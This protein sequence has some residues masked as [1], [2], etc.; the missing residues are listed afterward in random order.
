MLPG[1]IL[2]SGREYPVQFSVDSGAAQTVLGSDFA[3]LLQPQQLPSTGTVL[4]S[5]AG[6]VNSFFASL[7]LAFVD[8]ARRRVIFSL[9]CAVLTDARQAN[10]H[11]LGRDV[12]DYFAVICD[13][14]A[15]R[16]TLL[17]PPHTYTIRL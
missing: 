14:D 12:L 4:L 17:R 2:V 1:L 3:P 10:T 6:E 16:V 9:N 7:R 13:K 15:D 8:D 11:L 5:A